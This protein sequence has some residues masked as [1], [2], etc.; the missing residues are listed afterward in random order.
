L[1]CLIAWL[2]TMTS[3][4]AASM[5]FAAH[6]AAVYAKIALEVPDRIG[7]PQATRY[8]G[9]F[10]WLTVQTNVICCARFAM[11]L[12]AY[13]LGST[14]LA[15]LT[16]LFF[17]LSFGLGFMLTILYYGLDYFAEENIQKRKKFS[18]TIAPHCELAAHLSHGT[19]LPMAVLDACTLAA[20]DHPRPA[21]TLVVGGYVACYMV[22]TIVNHAA[23]RVWQYPIIADAQKAAGWAGVLGFF[24]AIMALM[25]GAANLGVTI[26][27][28]D[29]WQHQ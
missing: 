27:G 11:V 9:M 14:D 3:L 29:G 28:F 2:C 4:L 7:S 16:V 18:E 19:A 10:T 12:A 1:R 13:L 5:G 25:I 15:S 17:P 23:T 20:R 26:A 6:A 24:A 8:L 22:Q 21:V